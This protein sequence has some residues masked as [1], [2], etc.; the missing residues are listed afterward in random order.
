MAYYAVRKGKVPGIY[1]TWDE[2]KKNI[3]K[4]PGAEY[5]KF[6][7]KEEAEEFLNSEKIELDE[8]SLDDIDIYSFVDGSFN[9]K[10]GIYGYGGFLIDKSSGEEKKYIIQGSG[11]D[12]EMAT[13]R[14]IAGEILGSR[15]A[16][17]KAIE[18]NLKEI[19]IFY[20]YMGIEMWAN[21]LWERKKS[22]TKEYYEYC[23]SIKDKIKLH[24]VKVKGHTG[25]DGNEE[26]DALAK[27]SVGIE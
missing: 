9:S 27:E 26:A 11:S 12:K 3:M 21:G 4:F 19:V 8:V 23:Q 7:T 10:T 16:I 14:N 13:M 18:L 20:D 24:F 15:A 1:E 25:I 17:E 6:T 22:G 2:C 5:K